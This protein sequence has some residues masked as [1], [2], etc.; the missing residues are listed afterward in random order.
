MKYKPL[1]VYF[2]NK[3]YGINNKKTEPHNLYRGWATIVCGELR[4]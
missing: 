4:R 3:V 1:F 2:H